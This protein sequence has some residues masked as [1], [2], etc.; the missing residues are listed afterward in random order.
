MINNRL[1]TQQAI[2]FMTALFDAGYTE[3][4]VDIFMNTVRHKST[5]GEHEVE[6]P[7]NNLYNQYRHAESRDELV[8]MLRTNY[9]KIYDGSQ[10]ITLYSSMMGF[11]LYDTEI[12]P[13]LDRI[14]RK[15]NNEVEEGV[16][17]SI[18]IEFEV[19][20]SLVLCVVQGHVG[21]IAP[22]STVYTPG[23]RI[24]LSATGINISNCLDIIEMMLLREI[25][26]V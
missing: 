13:K 9:P 21:W 3:E 10:P 17:W 11:P 23:R 6:F 12:S 14:I 16:T 1:T 4:A 5:D 18:T 22:S 8:T 24:N 7:D 20:G 2:S 19:Y 26:R 25:T 15:L